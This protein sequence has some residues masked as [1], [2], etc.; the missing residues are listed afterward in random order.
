VSGPPATRFLA[1]AFRYWERRQEAVAH[2][3][4][5]VSTDG[6]RQE[7]VF[8]R[9]LAEADAPVAE[10]RTD[11]RGGALARTGNPM[12][13]AL[14][15]DGFLVVDTAAGRRYTRGGALAVDA[16]G[17]LV[18]ASGNPVLGEGGAMVLPPG[19]VDV[20]PDGEVR[21][22]G[23]TVGRLRIERAP[24]SARLVREGESLFVPPEGEGEGAPD[25]T[26]RVR[27]GHVESSNVDP[28]QA[29]VEMIEIQ[30]AV[31]AI[32]RSA[33]VLDDVMDTIANRL[34]RVE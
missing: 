16:S 1:G 8:A 26:T 13:V 20:R 32:E 23:S 5:N 28:V 29:M 25:V 4:A 7:R 14:E 10:G 17:T 30:R 27:Q 12:D 24:E 2:N 6:F 31:G 34:G 15:G 18:D 21:V 11:L 19:T 33:R 9:L 22:D 3:L